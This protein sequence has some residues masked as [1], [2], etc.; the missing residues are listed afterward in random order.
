MATGNINSDKEFNFVNTSY[1]TFKQISPAMSHLST[2]T[3]PR[4]Q[5]DKCVNECKNW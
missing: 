4:V 1:P 2:E 5:Y 3:V